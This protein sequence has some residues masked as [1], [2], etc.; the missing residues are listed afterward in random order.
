MRIQRS[1][2]TQ[3]VR[4]ITLVALATALLGA[5]SG[6]EAVDDAVELDVVAVESIVAIDFTERITATGE[7]L[8]TNHANIA[9]E[10]DGRVTELQQLIESCTR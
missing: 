4:R 1:G 9:A 3:F 10:V 5:C 7:L 6:S 2:R 8:A